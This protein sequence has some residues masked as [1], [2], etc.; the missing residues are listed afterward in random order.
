MKTKIKKDWEKLARMA[1]ADLCWMLENFKPIRGTGLLYNSK[2]GKTRLW[3]DRILDTIRE[4]GLYKIDRD[5]ILAKQLP[6]REF[7]KW[8]SKNRPLPDSKTPP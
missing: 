3:Q 8:L 6:R 5:L 2:T 1:V 4:S 7:Q